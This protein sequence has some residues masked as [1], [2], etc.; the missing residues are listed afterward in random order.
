MTGFFSCDGFVQLLEVCLHLQ[1][2]EELS[3]ALALLHVGILA[4]LPFPK[5]S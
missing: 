4:F 5:L 1:L 3:G 2:A